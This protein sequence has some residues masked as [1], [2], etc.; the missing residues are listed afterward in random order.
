MELV[1]RLIFSII[2]ALLLAGCDCGKG[3]GSGGGGGGGG[4]SATGGGAGGGSATGGGAGGGSAGCIAGATAITVTPP[5]STVSSTQPVKLTATAT[6]NGQMVD[7]SA[8]VTWTATR[9]DDTPPGSIDAS[10][11]FTPGAGG[12]V[13]VAASAAAPR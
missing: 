12:T 13:T 3:N 5:S 2:S 9:S 1:M 7:V 6:V 8:Q 4:G 11:N 10:G